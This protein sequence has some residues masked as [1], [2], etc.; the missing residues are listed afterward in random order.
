MSPKSFLALA[1]LMMVAGLV[2]VEQRD[3]RAG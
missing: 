3:A 1:V 2:L